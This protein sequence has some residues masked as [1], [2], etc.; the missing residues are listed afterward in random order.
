MSN[1]A[2]RDAKQEIQGML[3]SVNPH[4]PAAD[5]RMNASNTKVMSALNPCEQRQTFLMV[6]CEPLD[7]IGEFK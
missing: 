3:E 1:L 4:A 6:D 7:D 2:Y 5:L